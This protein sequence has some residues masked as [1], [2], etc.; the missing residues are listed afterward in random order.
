MVKSFVKGIL[1]LAFIDTSSLILHL[2]IINPMSHKMCYLL[3]NDSLSQEGLAVKL[4]AGLLSLTFSEMPELKIIAIRAGHVRR[5]QGLLAP[6]G[7]QR[8]H[9]VLTKSPRPSCVPR[10]SL[11]TG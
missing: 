9:I 2:V 11:Y 4:S 8:L 1:I 6:G 7:Q 10:V 3:P 5:G